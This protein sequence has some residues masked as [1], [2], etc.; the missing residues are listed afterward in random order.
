MKTTSYQEGLFKKNP[1]EFSKSVCRGE[2][3]KENLAPTFSREKANQHYTSNYSTEK[4]T[5]LPDIHWFP[6]V[7][8]GPQDPNFKPFD[9]SPI[10]PKDVS[11]VLRHANHKSSPGPDGLPFGILHHMPSTHH[12]LATLFNKVLATN[13]VPSQ[14]G[15]SIIKLIHKKGT[16]DDPGNF[17]PIALSNTIVKTFHLILANRTTS[18]LIVN[19]LVDPAIQKAFLP[20]ISGCTEHNAVMEEVIKHVKSKKTHSSYCFL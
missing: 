6:E 13:A 5:N 14:W 16:T 20:G 11:N 9:M 17:Q 3:G 4:I 2:F 1:W 19:K 12:V 8:T 7:K 18:F 15:E 10:R